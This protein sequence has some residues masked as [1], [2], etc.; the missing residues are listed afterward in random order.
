MGIPA[1][2]LDRMFKAF[3]QTHSLTSRR[4]GGTGLGLSISKHLVEQMNGKIGVETQENIGSTFWFTIKLNRA[5]K[6]VNDLGES[7]GSFV[8][9]SARPMRILIAED[10]IINQKI[11]LRYLKKRARVPMP[12]QMV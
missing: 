4:F 7:I 3:P 11:A 6:P 1:D 2:A 10:N 5:E 8:G 12:S 9:M